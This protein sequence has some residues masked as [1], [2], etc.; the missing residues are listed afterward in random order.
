M[1]TQNNLGIWM[2]H[3]AAHLINLKDKM[4]TINSKFDFDVQDEAI[5]KNE[6]LMHNKRQ[7]MQEAFYKDISAEILNYD[8]VLLFGPTNAR[9]ELHNFL[10]K[11]SHFKDIKVD[12]KAS[13]KMTD[14]QKEAFVREHFEK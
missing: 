7:Q 2:D 9:V 10:E 5:R 12:V 8:H 14:N 3:S 11:D 1:G 4:K 6:N 13:D